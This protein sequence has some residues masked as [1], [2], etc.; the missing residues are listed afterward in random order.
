MYY[1]SYGLYPSEQIKK[2]VDD[3]LSKT[4]F[5]EYRCRNVLARA[6]DY[7]YVE[8]L[9]SY[10][11]FLKKNNCNYTKLTDNI[12]ILNELYTNGFFKN[13]DVYFTNSTEVCLT[14]RKYDSYINNTTTS[15]DYN[16]YISNLLNTTYRA[17]KYRVVF[18]TATLPRK[19]YIIN[20]N[21]VIH[22]TVIYI[23]KNYSDCNVVVIS[24]LLIEYD[25]NSSS[26]LYK[27]S[28]IYNKYAVDNFVNHMVFGYGCITEVFTESITVEFNKFGTRKLHIKTLE[29]NN[30]IEFID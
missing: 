9:Y 26:L 20:D 10:A 29:D 8:F 19:E 22:E 2:L 16:K 21:D 7:E 12:T 15:H 5:N 27:A 28:F 6:F 17:D 11:D 23:L 24:D 1:R 14:S 18:Q 13:K 4:I 30:L 3:M 25:F